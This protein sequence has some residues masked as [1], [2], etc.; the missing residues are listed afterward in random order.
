MPTNEMLFLVFVVSAFSLFGLVLGYQSFAEWR[1]Q[2]KQK[3]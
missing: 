3:D 2:K 1:A